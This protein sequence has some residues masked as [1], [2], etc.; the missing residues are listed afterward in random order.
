MESKR[1]SLLSKFGTLL[2]TGFVD[3]RTPEIPRAQQVIS[4]EPQQLRRPTT[5]QVISQELPPTSQL[6]WITINDQ[7]PELYK[8]VIIYTN[9]KEILYNWARV[10][11]TDYIH[12]VDNRTINNVTHW[13]NIESPPEPPQN[14]KL[15]INPKGPRLPR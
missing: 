15:T 4:Q 6:A 12:S 7:K 10:N 2:F 3:A 11:N 14:P 8:K 13:I 9:D 5:Q 1:T